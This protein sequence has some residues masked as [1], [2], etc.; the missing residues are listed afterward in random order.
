MTQIVIAVFDIVMVVISNLI[1]AINQAFTNLTSLFY[2][3]DEGFTFIGTFLLIGLG[4][5]I[6]FWAFRFIRSLVRR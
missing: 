5:S 1:T 6:V 4:F 3:Q 2:S